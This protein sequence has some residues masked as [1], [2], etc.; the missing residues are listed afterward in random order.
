MIMPLLVKAKQLR[1]PL[2]FSPTFVKMH[3]IMN[4]RNDKKPPSH[5]VVSKT[6]LPIPRHLCCKNKND[7]RDKKA[8]SHTQFLKTFAGNNKRKNDDDDENEEMRPENPSRFL[9]HRG[10][11]RNDLLFLIWKSCRC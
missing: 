7:V 2:L 11:L 8:D 9:M 4:N 10:C 6:I 1:L 3:D 5:F